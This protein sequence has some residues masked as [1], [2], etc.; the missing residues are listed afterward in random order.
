MRE[1]AWKSAETE[2]SWRRS[3]DSRASGK[4]GLQWQ[5]NQIRGALVRGGVDEM[6]TAL[7]EKILGYTLCLLFAPLDLQ[8]CLLVFKVVGVANF[9]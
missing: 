2:S 8:S 4:R 7:L 9:K 3:L 6:H 1:E 5:V